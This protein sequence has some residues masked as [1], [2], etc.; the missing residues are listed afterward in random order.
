MW[1][2]NLSPSSLQMQMNLTAS[3]KPLLCLFLSIETISGGGRG[4]LLL[5]FLH[6]K[7]YS[8]YSMVW[9]LIIR[10]L[11]LGVPIAC[12]DLPPAV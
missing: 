1:T 8:E 5:D 6:K 4:S 7:V 11:K 3:P 12:R 2:V 9:S 10:R